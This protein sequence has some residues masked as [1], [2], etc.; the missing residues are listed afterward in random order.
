MKYIKNLEDQILI[1]GLADDAAEVSGLDSD[2]VGKAVTALDFAAYLELGNAVNVEDADRI[3]EILN[4]SEVVPEDPVLGEID[5]EEDDEHPEDQFPHEDTLLCSLCGS[6]GYDDWGN[7]CTRCGG[8]GRLTL[9]GEYIA[10]EAFELAYGY[11]EII[12]EADN[13]SAPATAAP[14]PTAIQ[15]PSAG[16][17]IDA[18]AKPADTA[19]DNDD[20]DDED[21]VQQRK[22]VDDLQIGDEIEVAD[23]DGQPAAGRVLNIHGPGNTIVITG[24]DDKEHMI[25]KDSILSTPL[26]PIQEKQQSRLDKTNLGKKNKRAERVENKKQKDIYE[27]DTDAMR[28]AYENALNGMPD[29]SRYMVYINRP[30]VDYIMYHIGRSQAKEGEPRFLKVDK[31]TGD[32]QTQNWKAN[33]EP[34]V[35]QGKGS[36]PHRVLDEE[37]LSEV[38]PPGMEDWIMKRKPEFKERYGKKWQEVLYAT[39]WKQHNNESIKEG[40][41]V[42]ITYKSS[43][44]KIMLPSLPVKK[45]E[46]KKIKDDA[47]KKGNK[48]K[49][50]KYNI[51]ESIEESEKTKRGPCDHCNGTGKDDGIGNPCIMCAGSGYRDYE[52]HSIEEGEIRIDHR[53]II[54]MIAP[55]ATADDMAEDLLRLIDYA[56]DD[57]EIEFDADLANKVLMDMGREPIAEGFNIYLSKGSEAGPKVASVKKV[58]KDILSKLAKKHNVNVE[59]LEWYNE[60]IAEGFGDKHQKRIAID[61]VKN[62]SKSLL[63]GP[64]AKEAE[65]TLRDKFGYDD[66][67]IAKLKEGLQFFVEPLGNGMFEVRNDRG[68]SHDVYD[69]GQEAVRVAKELN[70]KYG[71]V[72]EDSTRPI[73]GMEQ[74]YDPDKIYNPDEWEWETDPDILAYDKENR[75]L[76]TKSFNEDIKRLRELAGINEVKSGNFNSKMIGQRVKIMAVNSFGVDHIG[77]EGVVIY[78]SREHTFSQMVPFIVEYGIELDS[79]ERMS[80]RREGVRKLKIQETATGGSTGA[81]AIASSPVAMNGIQS[82]NQSIYGQT[83]L[84]KKPEAKKRPTREEAGDGIGRNKK[85]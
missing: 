74:D 2:A 1:E 19:A 22:E 24:K 9:D 25:H 52:D 46:A 39:A 17:T 62:P 64:S 42:I 81:G 51:D 31:A 63:G 23:I 55:H 57:L 48:A 79:G 7:T 15:P 30:D 27:I 61:T 43:G 37:T 41:K 76:R 59:D 50:V 66:K 70:A 47:E 60:S 54:D 49:I 69:S 78:A 72:D 58:T 36:G 18:L 29:L 13:P 85:T 10:N 32:W 38:A 80:I 56:F 16:S 53:Q 65:E 35:Q 3:R 83:K 8:Q 82:R 45:S 14:V 4:I 67:K 11:D 28:E 68:D 34:A 6:Q 44:N 5:L 26:I 73:L 40:F 75:E 84:R 12:S 71:E 21:E 20:D 77:E 33:N